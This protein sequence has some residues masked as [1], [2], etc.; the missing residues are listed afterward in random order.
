M[1][2][3]VSV[4]EYLNC[5]MYIRP[6]KDYV[7]NCLI[8]CLVPQVLTVAVEFRLFAYFSLIKARFKLI[9]SLINAYRT[10]IDKSLN[11]S[12]GGDVG[13]SWTIVDGDIFYIN[14]Y[15]RPSRFIPP[16]QRKRFLQIIK[17]LLNFK[18]KIDIDP[19]ENAINYNFNYVDRVMSIQTIYFKLLDI[20]ELISEAY[21]MQI[22]ALIA[23]QFITLTTLMYDFSMHTV[24]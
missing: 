18:A 5:L 3:A 9:N 24:R 15:P 12:A 13:A 22:I 11:R 16:P 19:G 10:N 17:A 7:E 23:V 4:T 2:T 21:G 14:D 8:L 20:I 1:F 6:V